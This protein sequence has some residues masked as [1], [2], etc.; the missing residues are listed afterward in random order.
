MY[1][2]NM[3]VKQFIRFSAVALMGF[4]LFATSCKDDR[5][6]QDSL[7]G[8]TDV[9]QEKTQEVLL[10]FNGKFAI[11][12]IDA[13]VIS[14]KVDDE[15]S[16]RSLKFKFTG[17]ANDLKTKRNIDFKFED[18]DKVDA[19]LLMRCVGSEFVAKDENQEWSDVNKRE[20][21]YYHRLVKLTYHSSGSKSN[22]HND[23]PYFS[24]D[25]NRLSFTWKGKDFESVKGNDQGRQWQIMLVLSKGVK[26][27]LPA[28]GNVPTRST[29]TIGD[30]TFDGNDAETGR[31]YTN[32]HET[33]RMTDFQP[34]C[35]Y[36]ANR[37][38]NDLKSIE[39]GGKYTDEF[40]VPFWSEWRTIKFTKTGNGTDPNDPGNLPSNPPTAEDN[41]PLYSFDVIPEDTNG[42]GVDEEHIHLKPRGVFVL[43]DLKTANKTPFDIIARG[44]HIETTSYSFFG[45]LDFSEQS[46]RD[47]NG[48]PLWTPS[49]ESEHILYKPDV[50]ISHIPIFS[51]DFQFVQ[52]ATNEEITFRGI[53]DGVEAP[54]TEHNFLFWAMPNNIKD[55]TEDD[56]Y[57]AMFLRC[58][59]S[60]DFVIGDSNSDEHAKW[61]TTNWNIRKYSKGHVAAVM[62]HDGRDGTDFT[63]DDILDGEHGRASAYIK[64]GYIANRKVWLHM[65]SIKNFPLYSSVGKCAYSQKEV[66][67]A[68]ANNTA[69]QGAKVGALKHGRIMYAATQALARPIMFLE[70]MSETPAV[71]MRIVNEFPNSKRAATSDGNGNYWVANE[72]DNDLFAYRMTPHWNINSFNTGATNNEARTDEFHFTYQYAQ[73]LAAN[74]QS[75]KYGYQKHVPTSI[76]YGAYFNTYMRGRDGRREDLERFPNP[77]RL[78]G[79]V[80]NAEVWYTIRFAQERGETL[81]VEDQGIGKK[82]LIKNYDANN[83]SQKW[84][85][86]NN[87]GTASDYS[88]FE[89]VNKATG[90]HIRANG[91]RFYSDVRN[92][93]L[94]IW[95]SSGVTVNNGQCAQICTQG[96]HLGENRVAMNPVGRLEA[97]KEIAVWSK[98]AKNAIS[99]IKEV[100]GSE[101]AP[102]NFTTWSKK[103]GGYER[104]QNF[105]S[106][107][108]FET[109][110]KRRPT[111]VYKRGRVVYAVRYMDHEDGR[112][113]TDDSRPTPLHE[114]NDWHNCNKRR[115]VVRYDATGFVDNNSSL[116]D[117]ALY[118]VTA[119][120]V[121][122]NDALASI[123][124]PI[125]SEEQFWQNNNQ[126]DV[127]RYY[128][129]Y[130]YQYLGGYNYVG[131]WGGTWTSQPVLSANPHPNS[132]EILAFDYWGFSSTYTSYHPYANI[133]GGY[134][135]QD[136]IAFYLIM[137]I[138]E[139]N[140]VPPGFTK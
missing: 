52:G 74:P 78:N 33:N 65:P 54:S 22:K 9:A 134:N 37:P 23:S 75:N 76:E 67:D 85:L 4:S 40:D 30:N 42:D 137:P 86:I 126:D 17:D 102:Y 109:E 14:E 27:I 26:D 99:W 131:T 98:G 96:V 41:K 12:P 90:G 95:G 108:G 136:R 50:N 16:L 43:I 115:C 36:N 39:T 87:T 62:P 19:M 119:R 51:K 47:N 8:V 79:N 53:K 88:N 80:A 127:V 72:K 31:P 100:D 113:C 1:N 6:V 123:E 138:K 139:W 71:N 24:C 5:D 107:L 38:T 55:A 57:T 129:K 132:V 116:Q 20:M 66:D 35:D 21:S 106:R 93:N 81:V 89:L 3:M 56:Y 59:V 103:I 111:C 45:N 112:T 83:D 114:D 46:M 125:W 29:L 110:G 82:L 117:K 28:S 2:R 11:D 77:L 32:L 133:R 130:G 48:E 73:D 25:M 140:T 91:D 34:I 135:E 84:K 105:P 104:N 124:N 94:A 61:I 101:F 68:I 13:N 15:E 18:G 70:Y 120:Y 121:G 118:S 92:G 7:D 44:I 49:Q 60:G 122:G 97:D 63:A 10:N 58:R 64:H 128:T 69:K